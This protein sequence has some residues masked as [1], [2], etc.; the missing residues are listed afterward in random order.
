[1]L[2]VTLTLAGAS[3]LAALVHDAHMIRAGG[4]SLAAGRIE[5]A[6]AR[7]RRVFLLREAMAARLRAQLPALEAGDRRFPR[8]APLLEA[9]LVLA[10]EPALARRCQALR[11]LSEERPEV[12]TLAAH[13][14]VVTGPAPAPAREPLGTSGVGPRWIAA[15]LGPAGVDA[16]RAHRLMRVTPE[17]R[18]VPVGTGWSG[19]LGRSWD[20]SRDAGAAVLARPDERLLERWDLATG[21]TT[22][23]AVAAPPRCVA[24]P[25]V[26]TD[27]RVAW[28]SARAPG[29]VAAQVLHVQQGEHVRQVFPP[30]GLQPAALG[31]EWDPDG[32][33]LLVRWC[34]RW[35]HRMGDRQHLTWLTSDGLQLLR[36]W[37]LLGPHTPPV[38]WV[39]GPGAW[40]GLATADA[41]WVWDG[42]AQKARQLPGVRGAWGWSP[43]GKLIAGIDVGHLFVAAAAAP[44]RRREFRL[45]GLAPLFVPDE[46]GLVWDA[47]GVR[48]TGRMAERAQ[49][50]WRNVRIVATLS[51]GD[52]R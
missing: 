18:R 35:P 28:G 40:I 31:C 39:P 36:A 26:G 41:A 49:G 19:L 5:E 52:V 22:P 2:L 27:G 14:V 1:L 37:R 25:P 38:R 23:V 51:V 21:R 9:L 43:R 33:T 47:E 8:E 16:E 48:L 13:E 4:E 45:T 42:R 17:G 6:A 29:G 11:V 34:D 20:V 32:Q 15:P 30:P 46:A 12:V 44:H 7:A 24:L 50:P 10:P 3:G